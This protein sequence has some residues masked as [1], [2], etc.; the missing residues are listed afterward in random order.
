MN[1]IFKY[2]RSKLHVLLFILLE[3]FCIIM[4]VRFNVRHSSFFFSHTRE[5]T[6]KLHE[7]NSSAF[8]Y[9][10]LYAKN[11]ALTNENLE[12]RRALKS[13][14]VIESKK[15]FE[16]NDT[17]FKQRYKYLPA[18]LIT[19]FTNGQ[20]NYITI[21]RG[22]ASGVEKNMGVFSSQGVIGTVVEVS[23]NYAIVQSILNT[24]GFKVAPKIEELNDEKGT[25]VWDG[26]DPNY[27][28]LENVNKYE[29]IKTGYHVVTSSSSKAFP[30]NIP[31]GTIE[32]I[33]KKPAEDFYKIQVRSAVNFG[34]IKTV[35][36]VVNLFSDEIE[37][38][39]A[40]VKESESQQVK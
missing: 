28:S 35:F 32:K 31:V 30:E 40:K 36:V 14:F 8:D 15:V 17:I 2:L 5:L 4:I 39:E 1:S 33:E 12:L 34:Q 22:S 27:L 38:L 21:N 6:S 11:E 20:N 37:T 16:V 24:T 19:K 3:I 13:N 23:D 25:V 9:F 29:P 10:A 7:I 18:S 26:R